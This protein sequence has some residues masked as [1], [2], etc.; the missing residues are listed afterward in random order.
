[1]TV[2][3]SNTEVDNI[4]LRTSSLKRSN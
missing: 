1:M 2:Q 4:Q 3:A